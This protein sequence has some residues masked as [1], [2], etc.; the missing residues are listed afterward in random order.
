[1]QFFIIKQNRFEVTGGKSELFVLVRYCNTGNEHVDVDVVFW[2]VTS[3]GLIGAYR[4]FEETYR[5]H[6]KGR[7]IHIF[8]ALKN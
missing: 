6:F 5:L 1:M 8:T 3:C 2:V 4:R 7:I